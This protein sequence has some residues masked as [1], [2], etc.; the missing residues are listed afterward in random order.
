MDVI[1]KTNVKNTLKFGEK[2]DQLGIFGFKERYDG[3][4]SQFYVCPIYPRLGAGKAS[5]LHRPMNTDKKKA[6]TKFSSLAE[7]QNL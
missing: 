3:E 6:Q 7:D 5:N 1:Y 2:A 4:F